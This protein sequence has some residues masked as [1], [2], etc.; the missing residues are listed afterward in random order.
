VR[1]SS[2]HKFWI[3]YNVRVLDQFWSPI[4]RV[5]PLKTPF[6]LLILLLQ[7]QSHVTTITHNYFLRCYAF[8]QLTIL[9]IRDYNHLLH[10]Y[11]GWLLSYRSLL[12]IITHCRTRKVFNS[13][14]E[15]TAI[16]SS[17]Y[18][19]RGLTP[20]IHFLRLLLKLLQRSVR[21][22]SARHGANTASSHRCAACIRSRGV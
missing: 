10:S 9:H 13:H 5:T 21:F 1:Y 20:R 22:C 8:T 2:L 15:P 3:L 17:Y 7:S 18:S 16:S 6:G 19:R 12:Q 11:T 14:C 4:V